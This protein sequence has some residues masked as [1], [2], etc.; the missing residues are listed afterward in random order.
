VGT[1]KIKPLKLKANLCS[2]LPEEIGLF[3]KKMSGAHIKVK[4]TATML[5]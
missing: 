2:Y 3:E 4:K 5:I 1:D